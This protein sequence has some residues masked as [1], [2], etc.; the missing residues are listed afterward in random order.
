MDRP[1]EPFTAALLA[2]WRDHNR[3]L[4]EI[5]SPLTDEQLQLRPSAEHWAV[6]QL[7]SNLAGGRVYWLHDI[8]GEGDDALRDSFRVASTTV[9]D[10]P[11]T[12]AGWEDDE[13]HPRT[14]AELTDALA[15]TWQLVEECL[16]RWSGEDYA[17]EFTRDRGRV[18]TFSRAWV[19]WHILEHDLEHGSEIALILR[20][21]GLPTL[22][23]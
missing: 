9:P 11:L 3:R 14:A 23:L 10:L 17:V 20:A 2:G 12:D 13:D 1:I 16:R 15:R 21:N 6:W 8:L 19:V 7:A 18:R 4:I 5:I 22:E